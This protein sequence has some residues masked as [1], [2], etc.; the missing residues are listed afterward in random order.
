M[1]SA[2]GSKNFYC[3]N[4]DFVPLPFSGHRDTTVPHR[5]KPIFSRFNAFLHV[6]LVKI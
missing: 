2:S 1:I 3:K 5:V 6:K 4:Y